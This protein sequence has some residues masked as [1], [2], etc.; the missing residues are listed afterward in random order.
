VAISADG[1]H[2]FLL[3]A[4][5]DVRDQLRRLP[6]GEAS[7]DVRHVPIEGVVLTDAELDHT[8]GLILLREGRHLPVYATA[9]V[10]DI[11]E[12]DS[13]VLPTTRAFSEVPQ[14]L[15]LLDQPVSLCHRDGAAAGLSVE[16]F[17]VPAGPPRFASHDEHGHTI[18]LLVHELAS[19]RRCAFVPGCGGLDE[20]LL[21]R[22]RG[23]D[24]LL[25]D[26]T[27]W[28]DDELI[29]LGIGTRTAR[30]LDHL[31]VAGAD[32]SLRLLADLPCRHRIYTHINN[33]NPMLLEDSPQHAAVAR[34]G[35]TI[36]YDGLQ[37]LL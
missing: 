36:G 21:H 6:N 9:A 24:A 16:A 25:F 14:T 13:R 10:A 31:P 34:A 30:Q 29:A 18:G 37:L 12:H 3:N 7:S 17:A 1:A 35:L 15:L 23:A 4:S 33:T 22:L 26:G 8:L 5:P 11:L 28:E 19:G 27:F 32:G 2:W 20:A